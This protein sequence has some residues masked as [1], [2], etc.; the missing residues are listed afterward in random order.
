MADGGKSG[1]YSSR[2]CWIKSLSGPSTRLTIQSY[3]ND[4]DGWRTSFPQETFKK[5]STKSTR[6]S[7]IQSRGP[8]PET[9]MSMWPT[10]LMA[11][12]VSWSPPPLAMSIW[13][14]SVSVYFQNYRELILKSLWNFIF[15]MSTNLGINVDSKVCNICCYP[16]RHLQSKYTFWSTGKVIKWLVKKWPQVWSKI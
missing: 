14:T 8:R 1:T 16:S 12:F 15:L 13:I 11:K 3:I 5:V 10:W 7:R 6:S 4:S 9:S 2:S